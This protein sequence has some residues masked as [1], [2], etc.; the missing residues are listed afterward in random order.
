MTLFSYHDG[1]FDLL[2]FQKQYIHRVS[3]YVLAILLYFPAFT[4]KQETFGGEIRL[5]FLD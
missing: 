2:K 1:F 4:L 5:P 3:Y